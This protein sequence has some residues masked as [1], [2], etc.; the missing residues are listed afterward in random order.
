MV[1]SLLFRKIKDMSAP[2]RDGTLFWQKSGEFGEYQAVVESA[3][4]M[5]LGLRIVEES[6]KT[7]IPRK[8]LSIVGQGHQMIISV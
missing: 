7:E 1:S 4:G 3:V 5:A 6:H 8:G 2:F